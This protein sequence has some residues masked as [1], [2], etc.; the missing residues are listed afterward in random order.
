M[1]EHPAAAARELL[2]PVATGPDE[3]ALPTRSVDRIPD[4]RVPESAEVH[5][6]LVRAAGLQTNRQVLGRGPPLEPAVVGDGVTPVLD[7]GHPLTIARIPSHRQID[8]SLCLIQLPPGSRQVPATHLALSDRLGQRA[9]G[10]V[11]SG[12]DEQAARVPIQPVDDAG[13]KRRAG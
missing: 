8:R 6:H 1:K 9:M 7:D 10:F 3:A 12:H 4:N 11:G 5:A 2:G 13:P